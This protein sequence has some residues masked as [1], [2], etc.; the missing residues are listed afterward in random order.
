MVSSSAAS[1]ESW[2]ASWRTSSPRDMK[3]PK[4]QSARWR[5]QKC[6]ASQERWKLQVLEAKK[7]LRLSPWGT[8]VGKPPWAALARAQSKRASANWEARKQ[9]RRWPEWHKTNTQG[10]RRRTRQRS[11]PPWGARCPGPGQLGRQSP[12]SRHEPD[13]LSELLFSD[14]TQRI[15]LFFLIWLKELNSFF[16]IW[17]KELNSFF[18]IWLKELNS[19]FLI[20]LEEFWSR[21][22]ESQKWTYFLN[23]TQRIRLSFLEY[24]ARNWTV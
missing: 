13:V 20:R 14:M 3:R 1:T 4:A 17:L 22:Y 21:Q 18:L 10:S 5:E 12:A 11:R 9:K 2:A 19:F 15:E 24:D 8:K 7:A 6:A 16:L 23:M